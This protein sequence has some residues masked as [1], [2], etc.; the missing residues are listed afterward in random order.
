MA[1]SQLNL[2]SSYREGFIQIPRQGHQTS[3]H[4][5]GAIE[6]VPGGG[7]SF[8]IIWELTWDLQIARE[9]L[10]L[11]EHWVKNYVFHNDA[12]VPR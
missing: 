2:I 11:T 5:T 7:K 9:T 6:T 12:Y 1:V 3:L 10:N 4:S 8:C